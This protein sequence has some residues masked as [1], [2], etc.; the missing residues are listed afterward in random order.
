MEQPLISVIIPIYNAEKYL[1]ACIDSVIAQT[2]RHL[3]ILLVDDGS[4]D[5][6]A[7]ICEEYILKDSRVKCYHIKNCGVS[8]ARNF[9]IESAHGEY[10]M[11]VDADDMICDSIIDSLLSEILCTHSELSICACEHFLES[12]VYEKTINYSQ[13]ILNSADCLNAL[14]YMRPPFKGVEI[15]SVWGKLY[16]RGK[17]QK[18]RFNERITI[19]EDFIFNYEY[20]CNINNIVISNKKEYCYRISSNS[21]M[22]GKINKSKTDSVY[23]LESYIEK[24]KASYYYD[25]LVSRIINIAIVVLLMIPANSDYTADML[26][27]EKL[28]K[29]YRHTVLMN[30]N[31]RIKVKSALLC[32]YFGF[33]LLRAFYNVIVICERITNGFCVSKD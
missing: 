10:I 25:G 22:N 29:S 9:G 30:K 7:E 26:K 18:I 32:S 27:I 23:E 2:Y 13:K 17:M 6:S 15:T 11:F 28:I 33:G 19:G 21:L 14:F 8:A 12:P 1:R 5:L 3:E 31:S 20:M 24:S 4:T 16:V